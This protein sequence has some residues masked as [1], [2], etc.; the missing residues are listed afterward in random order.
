MFG[1]RYLHSSA[2]SFR[3]STRRP[4]SS[5]AASWYRNSSI[6][7]RLRCSRF[8]ILDPCLKKLRLPSAPKSALRKLGLGVADVILAAGARSLRKIVAGRL[9]SRGRGALAGLERPDIVRRR[10]P[11]RTQEFKEIA[12]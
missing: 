7:A 12:E 4:S 1:T 8:G 11:A 2:N 5:R 3:H 6:S 10:E 9:G